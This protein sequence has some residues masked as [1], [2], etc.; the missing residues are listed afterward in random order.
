[1]EEVFGDLLF[2]LEYGAHGFDG[3]VIA[4]GVR[5]EQGRGV[6][7][8]DGEIDLAG[9]LASGVDDEDGGGG[10][11]FGE[12]AIEE[13]APDLLSR[14]ASGGAVF[15]GLGDSEIGKEALLDAGEDFGEVELSGVGGSRHGSYLR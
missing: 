3:D 9:A 14:V 10:E 11:A 12:V 1:M 7:V 5:E 4:G 13:V 15:E 8:E 6:V 2:N